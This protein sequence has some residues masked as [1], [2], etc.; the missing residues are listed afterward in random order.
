LYTKR[1]LK[2]FQKIAYLFG[3]SVF[4]L[5]RS[6][7]GRSYKYYFLLAIVWIIFACKVNT[8]D[9]LSDRL[10]LNKILK[11]SLEKALGRRILFVAPT[12]LITL[13]ILLDSII[14]QSFKVETKS[15]V[16]SYLPNTTII[17]HKRPVTAV[18]SIVSYTVYI[19]RLRTIPTKHY[20]HTTRTDEAEQKIF[21]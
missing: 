20:R 7:S 12:F 9:Y 13:S 3:N 1:S 16:I 11:M 8:V 15:M 14:S 5:L 19:G 18:R 6:N 17:D 2:S 21:T 4:N 10:N